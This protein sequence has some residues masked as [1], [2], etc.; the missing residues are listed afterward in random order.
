M[1]CATLAGWPAPLLA[2][3]LLWINLVTDALPAMALGIEPPEP[4]VMRRPPRD[5]DERVISL[6]GGLRIL[7]HGGLNAAVAAAS[8]CVVYQG[9]PQNL[10]QARTAAFAT[11]AFT[12]LTFS[13]GCRSFRYTLP[14]LGLLSNRWL[15]VA[16]AVSALVQVGAL[17]LPPLKELFRVETAPLGWEWLVVAG[18]SLAPV[19][20]VETG[21]LLKAWV[22]PQADA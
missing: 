5:P 20:V 10:P 4:D 6:R 19:T 8:F 13:F 17:T 7:L 16:I 21:K 15:I 12:Q 9:Q 11:L 2:I 1:F 14:Q 18:L 3:H 22:R